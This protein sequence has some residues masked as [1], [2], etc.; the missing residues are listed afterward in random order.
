MHDK[1]AFYPFLN[2][3][4]QDFCKEK[5]CISA[6]T[7][8]EGVSSVSILEELELMLFPTPS[9][10]SRVKLYS[11]FIYFG[12]LLKRKYERQRKEQSFELLSDNRN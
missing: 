9:T 1:K 6:V 5:Y 4:C 3:E 10:E 8:M 11:V 12:L 2:L 7:L